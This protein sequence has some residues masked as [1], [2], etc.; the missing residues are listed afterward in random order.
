MLCTVPYQN[1]Q[2]NLLMGGLND[3]YDL[4]A[5]QCHN[6]LQIGLNWYRR[7]LIQLIPNPNPRSTDDGWKSRMILRREIP[8]KVISLILP[9]GFAA[10]VV[11]SS[12]TT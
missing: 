4:V 8:N 12:R 9:Q 6:Q 5:N 11:G 2:R 10:G 7:F 3:S 1:V